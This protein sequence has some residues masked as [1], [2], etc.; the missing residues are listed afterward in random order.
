MLGSNRNKDKL[1]QACMRMQKLGRGQSVVFLASEEIRRKI[2][3]EAWSRDRFSMSQE[4]DSKYLENEAQTV[5][6][7]YDNDKRGPDGR[8]AV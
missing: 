5:E 1:V 7:R 2:W 6:E 3:E 8:G 4:L